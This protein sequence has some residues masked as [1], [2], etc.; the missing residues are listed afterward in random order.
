MTPS[1][2]GIKIGEVFVKTYVS[3]HRNVP[4][5]VQILLWYFGIYTLLPREIT[6]ALRDA[7]IEAIFAVIALGL[8]QAAYFTEDLRS[9][10]RSVP[11]GQW[12][13]ARTSGIPTWRI[14][15]H[16]ILPQAMRVILPPSVGVYI[17]TLKDSS[18]A[19]II[20]YVELT[21]AGLLVREATGEDVKVLAVIALLYFVINYTISL[22]GG[23]LERRFHIV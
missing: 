12:E 23:A 15:K 20:G 4:T 13:A 16:I 22:V 10:L 3:Y 2:L 11:K 6:S 1:F 14:W 5:L 18:L 17:A 7:N 8:C 21:K 9:G 19:A